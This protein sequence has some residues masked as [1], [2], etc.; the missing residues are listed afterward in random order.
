MNSQHTIAVDARDSG[1][2]SL[3]EEPLGPLVE[4]PTFDRA[5]AGET[6]WNGEGP[7]SFEETWA[8]PVASLCRATCAKPS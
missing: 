8:D 6:T 7:H 4:Q 1:A 2:V 5:A 3:V